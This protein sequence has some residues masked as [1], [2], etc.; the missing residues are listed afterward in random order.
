[1]ISPLSAVRTVGATDVTTGTGAAAP[2]AGADF[3][4]VLADV[5]TDAVDAMR[6]GEAT[7]ISGIKGNASV[8]EVVE[9]V[10]TAE[11]TL[12]TAIAVRDKLVA[13]YQEITRMQI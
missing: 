1:M 2:T 13:A 8:Q 7:A 4:K 5:A 9:A 3:A 10:M 6:A 12:Q 11:Q